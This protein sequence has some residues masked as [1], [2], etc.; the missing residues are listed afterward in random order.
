M[1]E[2]RFQILFK[3]A[4]SFRLGHGSAFIIAKNPLWQK[5]KRPAI[6]IISMAEMKIPELKAPDKAFPL[7][8]LVLFILG[9]SIFSFWFNNAERW[10]DY[11]KLAAHGKAT[12]GWVTAK[13]LNQSRKINYSFA[14]D[15]RIYSGVGRAG[16]DTPDFK[17]L[18][19][20]DEVLI[21]YLPEKPE[22]SVLGDPKS[23]LR[24]QNRLLA[25]LFTFI[26]L[27]AFLILRR[28]L[29]KGE[30]QDDRF[31]ESKI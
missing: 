5:N 11:K 24:Q 29:K 10:P 16:F 28:E 2:C 25:F 3:R 9:I 26:A 19:K 18:N 7:W 21:F 13:G 17:N 27:A 8:G 30:G 31:S 22:T 20:G 1:R 15:G 12:A 4:A 23:H 14:A 6:L